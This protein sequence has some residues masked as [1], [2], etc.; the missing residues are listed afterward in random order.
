[1]IGKK[2]VAFALLATCVLATNQC[3]PSGFDTQGALK[4][5]FDLKWYVG[6]V[7]TSSKWYTQAQMV[8]SYLPA[9][10]MRCV[11]AEYTLLEKPTFLGYNVKVSN[12]AE[13]KDGKALGPLTEICA[14]VVDEKEGKLEVSPCFLPKPLAGPYWIEAFDQEAGWALVSGGPP[15]IEGTDGCK[16]GTGTNDSGLW[17]FTRRQERDEALVSKIRGIAES[18]GF[19]ASVLKDTDQTNCASSVSSVVHV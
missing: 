9:D 4:G 14:K 6:D 10:Y 8:I 16:T 7:G 1:M 17:I 12:H 3:P 13:N 15:K 5:G 2:S 11:T 18:K 19:D